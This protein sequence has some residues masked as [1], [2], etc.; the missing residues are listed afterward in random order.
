MEDLEEQQRRRQQEASWAVVAAGLEEDM[1]QAAAEMD[2]QH[3]EFGR[4][5]FYCTNTSILR[6]LAVKIEGLK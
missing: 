3:S 1:P 4:R 5:I 2:M 6:P